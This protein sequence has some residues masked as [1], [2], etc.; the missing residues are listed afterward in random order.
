MKIDVRMPHPSADDVCAPPLDP[1]CAPVRQRRDPERTYFLA[2]RY[3]E[4]L[5]RPVRA[6]ACG[7][8]CDDDACEYS[9]VS[10][11]FSLAILDELPE[12]HDVTA[13]RERDLP[14]GTVNSALDRHEAQ[15]CSERMARIGSRP[16]PS[17]C[18]PWLVLADIQIDA[19]GGVTVDAL[20]HRRFLASL[21]AVGFTCTSIRDGNKPRLLSDVEREALKR[22]FADAESAWADQPEVSGILSA[23][24]T[25]L[26]KA[27]T[28]SAL[29]EFLRN[30]SVH[31]LARFDI[32]ALEAEAKEAGVDTTLV[33]QV[34][35]AARL[36]TRITHP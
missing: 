2:I 5:E 21:A 17:C 20:T 4:G 12:C 10:E 6:G 22:A 13:F 36:V 11:S 9:R 26:R 14:V 19:N 31:D 23:P 1:W 3:S 28:N 25:A 30:R 32:D 8:G 7:C 34:H 15:A 27:K 29:R 35:E 24:A 18:S 33:R 16:C